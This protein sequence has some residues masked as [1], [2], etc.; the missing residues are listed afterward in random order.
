MIEIEEEKEKNYVKGIK[1]IQ[2][3]QV[4]IIYFKT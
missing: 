1:V 3:T 2:L 4:Q